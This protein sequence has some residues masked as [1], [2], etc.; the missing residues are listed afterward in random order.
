M[1]DPLTGAETGQDLHLFIG[2]VR[3]DDEGDV[4]T[5]GLFRGVLE[6]PLC[7]VFQLWMVPS[8]DLLTMA[9]SDDSTMDAKKRAAASR[10]MICCSK[11]RRSEMSLNTSTQPTTSPSLQ[12]IERHCRQSVAPC[13]LWR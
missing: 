1:F 10:S 2:S 4:M 6:E 7:A 13:R 11:R 3:R 9:S 8:S 12:R 5:N